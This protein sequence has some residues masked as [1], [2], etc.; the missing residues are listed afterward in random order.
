MGMYGPNPMDP[1]L[2][3]GMTSPYGMMPGMIP[4]MMPGAM[5]PPGMNAAAGGTQ[6]SAPTAA[7]NERMAEAQKGAWD[8]VSR[9]TYNGKPLP[10][11]MV[12][13]QQQQ[14]RADRN[15]IFTT[16]IAGSAVLTAVAMFVAR[17]RGKANLRS[18]RSDQDKL[19]DQHRNLRIDAEQER[20]AARQEAAKL[21]TQNQ[22]LERS[23]SQ[24]G[25]AAKAHRE[26]LEQS[27]QTLQAERAAHEAA[28]KA[29]ARMIDEI[30]QSPNLGSPARRLEMVLDKH[31]W[32]NLADLKKKTA[33]L[34]WKDNKLQLEQVL[35]TQN[36]FRSE[37]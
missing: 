2:M 32:E 29:N 35:Y 21:K 28:Q 26:A 15:S 5:L 30:I 19:I 8:G 20:N 1:M 18:S 33:G 37:L 9:D 14:E 34:N 22:Q 31:P 27:R 11:M 10:P 12:S 7:P 13:P 23:A 36:R 16:L 4:P 6:A 25:E 3:M 17:G 24:S